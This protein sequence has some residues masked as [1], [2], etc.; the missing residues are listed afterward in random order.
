MA[1]YSSWYF[2]V[3]SLG[4]NGLLFLRFLSRVEHSDLVAAVDLSL[5]SLVQL[6]VLRSP[7]AW[8]LVLESDGMAAMFGLPWSSFEKCLG[9]SVSCV[10]MLHTS[11]SGEQ[12]K[13]IKN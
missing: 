11:F 7:S 9:D 8:Y 2:A 5:L 13:W 12:I 4:C 1:V 3:K 10:S 6:N